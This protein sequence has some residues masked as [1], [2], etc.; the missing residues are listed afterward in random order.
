MKW[1]H[2]SQ[3]NETHLNVERM[4]ASVK[5]VTMIQTNVENQILELS[6]YYIYDTYEFNS[7]FR[8]EQQIL[9]T[10]GYYRSKIQYYLL[11]VEH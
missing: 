9:R 7:E 8:I 3:V 4:G 11:N 10:Y 5:T 2:I 1:C 6:I